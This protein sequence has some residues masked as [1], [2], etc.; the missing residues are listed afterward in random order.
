MN[1]QI[2]DSYR[3]AEKIKRVRLSR[4]L[5]Q[6]E[7]GDILGYSERQVRRLESDGTL[8]LGVINLI[9]EK[10]DLSSKSILFD[11]ED[12]F[13]YGYRTKHVLTLFYLN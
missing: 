1:G 5:T 3:I 13:L 4:G 7:M 10:F 11:D 12:A 9:S 2:I 8:N 6:I